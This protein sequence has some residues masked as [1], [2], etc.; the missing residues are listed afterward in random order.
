VWDGDPEHVHEWVDADISVRKSMNG[1]GATTL[2]RHGADGRSPQLDAVHR[3]TLSQAKGGVCP[4]GA[5]LGSHGLE[6]TPDCGR[7]GRLRLR[8]DLTPAQREYVAQ[9]LLGVAP[10][11]AASGDKDGTA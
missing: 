1:Q 10:R 8:R 6:P 4:C 7:R 9:R 5:W 3:E 11:D 2:S